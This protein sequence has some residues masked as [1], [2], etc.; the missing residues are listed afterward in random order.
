MMKGGATVARRWCMSGRCCATSL[1]AAVGGDAFG[2]R[3]GRNQRHALRLGARVCALAAMRWA[4]RLGWWRGWLR[5]S[6]SGHAVAL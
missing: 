5:L 1:L 6:L 3:Q 4:M 2:G